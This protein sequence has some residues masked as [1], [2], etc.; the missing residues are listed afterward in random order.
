M[1]EWGARRPVSSLRNASNDLEGIVAP[2]QFSGRSGLKRRQKHIPRR[3]HIP[4][5]TCV[6]CRRKLDKR[7]LTRIVRS[8][9]AGV[10]VDP[11]GKLNGRGAYLC[12]NG[13]CWDKA[14]SERLL[15]RALLTEVSG[16]EMARLA[17][18]RPQT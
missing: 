11:S 8:L 7:R 5:R 16:D 6:A 13:A 1:K 17:M 9:E 4:Q 3:K 2:L 15:D 18:H 14:L 10:V 12:D